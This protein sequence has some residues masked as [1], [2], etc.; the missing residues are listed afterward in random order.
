MT[1]TIHRRKGMPSDNKGCES[2]FQGERT[3]RETKRN[4]F[5]TIV[6]VRCDLLGWVGQLVE[7]FRHYNTFKEKMRPL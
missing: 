1:G 7:R 2:S 6:H 5:L 4:I 3:N